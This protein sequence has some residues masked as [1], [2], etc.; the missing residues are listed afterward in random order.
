MFPPA[1]CWAIRKGKPQINHVGRSVRC[2]HLPD[3]GV[4]LCV[5]ITARGQTVGLLAISGGD[6]DSLEADGETRRT[7]ITLSE[8]VALALV[9]LDLRERL[10]N[11]ALRDTLTNL[12]NRRYLEEA[13]ERELNRADRLGTALSII[14]IDIDHFKRFNDQHGHAAGDEVLKRVSLYLMEGCRATDLV[15]RL[16]GE[17]LLIML[18]DTDLDGAAAMAEKLR[19]DVSH[20][21]IRW[22]SGE[23]PPV[24]VSMGVACYPQ[25]ARKFAVLHSLADEALYRAKQNGRNQVCVWTPRDRVRDRDAPTVPLEAKAP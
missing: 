11:Q 25:H 8:Q 12:Y 20:L 10:E 17:E 14:A 6:P 19:D 21:R 16:G 3:T 4:A 15:C 18:P 5:P 7:A 9:N 2:D 1:D 13:S 24:T 23:L 22:H